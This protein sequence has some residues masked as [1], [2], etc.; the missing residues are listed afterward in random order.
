MRSHEL[1]SRGLDLLGEAP[2]TSGGIWETSVS[3]YVSFVWAGPM[4]IRSDSPNLV[5]ISYAKIQGGG[6]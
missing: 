2:G 5:V 1:R 3:I 6:P 4:A